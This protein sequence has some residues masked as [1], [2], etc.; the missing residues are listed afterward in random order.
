MRL[1]FNR[2]ESLWWEENMRNISEHTVVV[3]VLLTALD[4]LREYKAAPWTRFCAAPEWSCLFR[5]NVLLKISGSQWTEIELT[6]TPTRW[7]TVGRNCSGRHVEVENLFPDES[8]LSVNHIKRFPKDVL[9]LETKKPKNLENFR[10]KTN[11]DTYM[12]YLTS[13]PVSI[14][15][16]YLR[17]TSSADEKSNLEILKIVKRSDFRRNN[18]HTL[19]WTQLFLLHTR[20]SHWM[21]KDKL[22]LPVYLPAW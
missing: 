13:S 2:T 3:L 21:G 6:F 17:T 19:R 10:P 12:Y 8:R 7:K 5:P 14:K 18:T 22:W 11:R 15:S 1:I 16:M 4:C 9:C 20:Q